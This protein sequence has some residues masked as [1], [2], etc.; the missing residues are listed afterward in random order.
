MGEWGIEEPSYKLVQG[1]RIEAACCGAKYGDFNFVLHRHPRLLIPANIDMWER[2]Y[3][4]CGNNYSIVPYLDR[5]PCAI[6]AKEVYDN[7]LAAFK[8]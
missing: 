3:R 6:E 2:E 1:K 8:G 4:Y 7:A 5:H